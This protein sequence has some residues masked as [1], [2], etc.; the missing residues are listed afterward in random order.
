MGRWGVTGFSN[1]TAEDVKQDYISLLRSGKDGAEAV[2]EL[3]LRYEDA[4][5]DSDD[6]PMF[7][8]ALADVQWDY[9]RLEK[10]VRDRALHAIQQA[11]AQRS[12]SDAPAAIDA[13][14]GRRQ[15]RF[16]EQLRQKL[17][18]QPPDKKTVRQQKLYRCG[19]ENGD[20]YAYR[21]TSLFAAEKAVK[22]KYVFFV[23][24]GEQTW[25]PGHVIPVVYVYRAIGDDVLS[26]RELQDLAYL[27][28]FFAPRAYQKD[29]NRRIQYL[30][31]IISTSSGAVPGKN[32]TYIGHFENVQ[33]VADEDRNFYS[34]TWKA[35]EKYIL[36]DFQAWGALPVQN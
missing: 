31:S 28:Q 2:E 25:H 16:L 23:K 6:G 29:P 30:L 32:L 35:F 14:E 12:T 15:K 18:S 36:D 27:P 21:L 22:N 20:V 26:L 13:R 10:H 8:L 19:W 4:L 5:A 33:R 24:V 1:D 3:T 11:L 7:W 34:V 17:L 9:G